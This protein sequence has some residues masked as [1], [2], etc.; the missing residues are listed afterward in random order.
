MNNYEYIFAFAKKALKNYYKEQKETKEDSF[1]QILSRIQQETMNEMS[2]F[3]LKEDIYKLGIL[4]YLLKKI[5]ERYE[6]F[7]KLDLL[8]NV[9]ETLPNVVDGDRYQDVPLIDSL[10]NFSKADEESLKKL[11]MIEV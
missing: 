11:F 9:L 1:K 7:H 10:T 5:A 6:I 8:I 4:L 2:G 3:P